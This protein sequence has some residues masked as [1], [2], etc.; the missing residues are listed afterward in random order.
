M[1]AVHQLTTI[2]DS[3]RPLPLGLFHEMLHWY[4]FLRNPQRYL[5]ETDPDVNSS[6]ENT[7][8]ARAYYN[9]QKLDVAA[10]E[11]SNSA[12]F[13]PIPENLLTSN[14]ATIIRC[15][16]MRTI[17]GSPTAR[18]DTG[19][20]TVVNGNI[21]N[22]APT[23][24]TWCYCEGDDLSENAYRRSIDT[25]M[26]WGHSRTSITARALPSDEKDPIAAANAVARNCY[27]SITNNH[28]ERWRVQPDEAVLSNKNRLLIG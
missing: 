8:I 11:W 4:H 10:P 7:Y 25:Y 24:L 3:P 16:E 5:R 15:E 17:L 26:R 28:L 6:Y 1:N 20:N 19:N 9:K 18:R 14:P 27:T 21:I 22:N 2:I 23:L 13:R 12:S